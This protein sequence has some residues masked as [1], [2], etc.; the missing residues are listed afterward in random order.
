MKEIAWQFEMDRNV[1]TSLRSEWW[2]ETRNK[3]REKEKTERMDP[4]KCIRGHPDIS[5]NT[6][7][8]PEHSK[9]RTGLFLING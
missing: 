6:E 7:I 2:K 5:E 3:A 1:I 9:P 4:T 8:S